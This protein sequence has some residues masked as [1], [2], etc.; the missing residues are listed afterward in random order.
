MSI[1]KKEELINNRMRQ[2]EA[3]NKKMKH[4]NFIKK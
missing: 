1:T 2:I 3:A 4:G